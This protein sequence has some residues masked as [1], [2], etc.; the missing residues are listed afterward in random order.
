MNR[1]FAWEEDPGSTAE[2]LKHKQAAAAACMAPSSPVAADDEDITGFVADAAASRDSYHKKGASLGLR[3]AE[4]AGLGAAEG[5][6]LG[7]ELQSK[8]GGFDLL[9]LS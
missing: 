7:R 8:A 9:A 2:V 4:V 6:G 1:Q 3:K 5:S